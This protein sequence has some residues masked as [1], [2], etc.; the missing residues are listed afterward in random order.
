[1]KNEASIS[2]KKASSRPIQIDVK[3]IQRLKA[4][5][6]IMLTKQLDK[7]E[8]VVNVDESSFNRLTKQNYT[9]LLKGVPGNVK[10]IQFSGS[11][12]LITAISTTGASYSSMAN[13]TTDSDWFIAFL[14]KLFKEI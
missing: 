1:M 13:K 4:L 14:H 10:N 5:F 8:W 3:I 6:L 9:W 7:I 11:I 12:N 2:F